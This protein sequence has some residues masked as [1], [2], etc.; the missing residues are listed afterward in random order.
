MLLESKHEIYRP[1]Q[2]LNPAP[3]TDRPSW[4]ARSEHRGSPIYKL[5][6]PCIVAIPC[7]WTGDALGQRIWVEIKMPHED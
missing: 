3:P 7:G 4:C 2:G 6:V 1:S 5:C